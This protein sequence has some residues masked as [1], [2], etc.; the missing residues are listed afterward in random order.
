MTGPQPAVAACRTAVRRALRGLD[1]PPGLLLVAVSGG[2]D[3]LAL[4]AAAAFV[5]PREGWRAGAVL[6]DHGLQ[7]GSADV[8]ERVAETCRSLGLDPVLAVRAAVT[9][10]GQGPEAAARAARYAALDAAA[11][12]VGAGAVLLGHTR[13]DQAETVLLALARGS[14]TR[15]LQGM[16]AVRGR[17]VRP[18]LDVP[19]SVTAD[20]CNQL[21]LLVWHD[22][23]NDDGRFTRVRTRAL[24]PLLEAELG[25][26]VVA[27]LA[28]SAALARDD[29]DA[30]QQLAVEVMADVR[31]GASAAG[32]AVELDVGALATQH[33][34][35]RRRVL[36][37]AVTSAAGAAVAVTSTHLAALDALVTRWRGQGPVALPGG[38]QGHR[39]TAAGGPRVVVGRCGELPRCGRLPPVTGSSSWR[40]RS[41]PP[42][43]AATCC[44]W[45]S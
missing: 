37:L 20:A 2:A 15:S 44:S 41:T 43:P 28:R 6:V 22:P 27:G 13:D 16:A 12:E 40:P 14:G 4:A 25:P 34:A 42:T 7:P 45:V 5:A 33:P 38:L 3:S 39:T 1:G 11:D 17:L 9:A 35:V 21:D 8:V 36:G 30:L 29:E 24:L 32:T 23:H 26:G 31:R 10:T 18:L 19:R